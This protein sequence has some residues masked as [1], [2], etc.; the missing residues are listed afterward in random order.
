MF[1]KDAIPNGAVFRK[2]VDVFVALVAGAPP[3]KEQ[4]DDVD[5]PS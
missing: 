3:S 1:R 5:F 2:Q 4:Q